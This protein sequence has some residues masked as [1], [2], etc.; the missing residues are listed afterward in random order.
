MLGQWILTTWNRISSESIIK[1]FKKCCLSN[2]IDGSEDDIIWE[3]CQ[4]TRST[5]SSEDDTS[6]DE[7][8]EGNE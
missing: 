7:E 4:E 2:A 5:S 6:G 3:E 1:G 8:D